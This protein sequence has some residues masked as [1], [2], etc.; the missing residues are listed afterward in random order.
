MFIYTLY[1][2][3]VFFI[4]ALPNI[5]T[6]FNLFLGVAGIVF[7]FNTQLEMAAFCIVVAAVLDF[8]DGFLARL[9]GVSSAI[10]KQLDSLADLIS[11]GLLPSMILF[12]FIRI[13]QNQYFEDWQIGTPFFYESLWAFLIVIC[14]ALRLA[15]F[16]VSDNQEHHFVGVPTPAIALFVGSIT[17]LLFDELRLNLYV[18]PQWQAIVYLQEK[19]RIS[20]FDLQ[21]VDLFFAKNRY[22]I[23]SVCLSVLMVLPFKFMAFKPKSKSLKAHFPQI[24]FLF[25]SLLI[26]GYFGWTHH[27]FAAFPIMFLL[28]L[29]M[30]IPLNFKR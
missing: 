12:Q 7:T 23:L 18:A 9:L 28:Y 22:I 8:L 5:A 30:S 11:F 15:K 21:L 2:C 4:K 3:K 29:V 20:E 24:I 1:F 10:G 13:H 26:L 17:L 19:R 16:N 6:L 27:V 25:L 14:A